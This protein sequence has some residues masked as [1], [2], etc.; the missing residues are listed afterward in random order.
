MHWYCCDRAA[1]TAL[2]LPKDYLRELRECGRGGFDIQ[3]GVDRSGF[4]AHMPGPISQA[5][6][7]APGMTE[8]L[9]AM[10]KQ[11]QQ[12]HQQSGKL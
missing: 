1:G 7:R 6:Y 3:A 12:L 9:A 2:K 10:R 5:F 4:V 8:H 11:K